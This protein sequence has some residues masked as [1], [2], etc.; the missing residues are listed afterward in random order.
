MVRSDRMFVFDSFSLNVSFMRVLRLM[1]MCKLLRM[2]R[3]MKA[4]R[5]LRLILDSIMGS[6]KSMLW[7]IVLVLTVSFMFGIAFVQ[8]ALAFL[9]RDLGSDATQE[10]LRTH[11]GS[12]LTAMFSL[13]M[14]TS[15]G[16]DWKDMSLSMADVGDGFFIL[17]LIYIGFYGCVLTNTLTSLFVEASLASAERDGE[18]LIQTELE[19]K[20]QYVQLLRKW[21][22]NIDEDGSGNL[23]FQEFKSHLTDP[24]MVEFTTAM[25]IDLTDAKHFFDVLSDYGKRQVDLETFVIGCTKLKGLAKSMDLM[26]LLNEHRQASKALHTF[27]ADCQQRFLKFDQSLGQ[28][29]ALCQSQRAQLVDFGPDSMFFSV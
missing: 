21:Y 18:Q 29:K 25:D 10:R 8:A 24:E 19:R 15:G 12:V 2:I 26:D 27:I 6:L 5:E 11:W 9:Q 28:V 4:F 1:K 20:D 13:F 22:S 7:A 23:E 17:F 14:A 16:D 3:L